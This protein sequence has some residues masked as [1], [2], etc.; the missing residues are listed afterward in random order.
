MKL[1]HLALSIQ[2]ANDIQP[3]YV[4]LLGFK[5]IREFTINA[6][7]ATK[8]FNI[9]KPCPVFYLEGHGLALELFIDE[10]EKQNNFNHWCFSFPNREA[11]IAKAEKQNATIIRI[12]RN[13]HDLLFI[14]D[15]SENIFE[16]KED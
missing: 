13:T 16:I 15:A 14:K 11:F 7:W 1:H 9:K 4:N 3:F 8:I 2:N 12:P 10:N 5:L 6:E